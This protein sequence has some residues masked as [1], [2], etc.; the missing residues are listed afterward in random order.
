MEINSFWRE[1]EKEIL[2]HNDKMNITESCIDRH[3]QEQPDKTALIFEDEKGNVKN[4]TYQQL[5]LEVNK[6]SNLL[7]SL[8]L[9]NSRIALFLPK[10][11]EIY[12]SFLAAIKSGN[13]AVPLFE[14]FQT[15]GLELRLERGDIEVLITNSEL[16]KRLKHKPETL[17]HIIIVDSEKFKQEIK[18]Q[19]SESKTVL[20]DRKD[21]ATMIFTS[22]T[23]GTPVAGV[24]IPQQALIQQH[25]TASHILELEKGSKYWCTAHPGWVTGAVYGILAP[26]SIGCSIYILESHFDAKIWLNFLKKNKISVMYTAPTALRMLKS[27][28]KK[29]DLEYLKSI[30]SVGEALNLSIYDFYKKLGIDINDTYWQTETGAIVIANYKENKKRAS[31]GKAIPGITAEIKDKTIALKPD[32]PSLMTGIYKHEKMYKEYFKGKWFRTN[33]SATKDEQGYFSFIGRKDDIIKTSGER[34]SPIELESVLIKNKAVK[35]AAV[36]GIPNKIKG[37]IIKA[38]IVLNSGF[39]ESE[40]LKEE[41]SLF[42][43]NN[44]AGHSYPKINQFIKELPKTNSGKIIRMKLREMESRICTKQNKNDIMNAGPREKK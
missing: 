4:Y 40:E 39:K 29:S 35:E 42:V 14:A 23:A 30:S 12:I 2:I 36:I 25:F 10:V 3:V 19:N 41:L 44:Y 31:L 13:I 22:S 21:T 8:K 11:P 28:I 24:E 5:N 38:F 15:Q 20:K 9:K 34:V 43:K 18:N 32:F 7:S 37:Q 1:K 16:L 17:K 33:D 27:E 26:L 6:F